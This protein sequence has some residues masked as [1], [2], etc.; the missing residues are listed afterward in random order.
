MPN[1]AGSLT[2]Y[3]PVVEA[4]RSGIYFPSMAALR[5]GLEVLL[6]KRPAGT[7][8][9]YV[10]ECKNA[11]PDFDLGLIMM[12][13]ARPSGAAS[14]F[15]D[16]LFADI[17]RTL[18]TYHV[19]TETIDYCGIGPFY[20]SSIT[21]WKMKD[22]GYIYTMC[23]ANT[24]S[25]QIEAPLASSLGSE[26]CIASVVVTIRG[27]SDRTSFRFDIGDICER[28]NKALGLTLDLNA[29]VDELMAEADADYAP[30]KMTLAS[31]D[32]GLELRYRMRDTGVHASERR[33]SHVGVPR[34]RDRHHRA[35]GRGLHQAGTERLRGPAGR[36]RDPHGGRPLQHVDP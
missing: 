28:V 1:Q 23:A 26:R 2:Q 16:S 29:V 10:E 18:A 22:G 35:A 19:F 6:G 25:E 13:A 24:L 14:N 31:L 11:T 34:R 9:A 7:Q 36:P 32:E 20:M 21:V 27:E 5:H 17:E 4:R 12:E 3:A 8:A 15:L 33:Q 30:P